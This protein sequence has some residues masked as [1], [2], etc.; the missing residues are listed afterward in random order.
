[1]QASYAIAAY[2][3]LPGALRSSQPRNWQ[4]GG[5]KILRLTSY[6]GKSLV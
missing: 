6:N 3:Q 1:M 2:D 5:G 4:G